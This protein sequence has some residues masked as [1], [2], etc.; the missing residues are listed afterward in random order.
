MYDIILVTLDT[1]PTD[2]AI[3]K[4][5]KTLASIMHSHVVLLHVP[6]GPAAQFRGPD[7]GG[8]EIDDSQAYLEQGKG[9]V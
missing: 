1:S 6:T 3:I 7:A 2:R 9:G 8:K 5:I 4:H